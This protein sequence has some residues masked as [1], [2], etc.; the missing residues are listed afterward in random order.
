M[1]KLKKTFVL[2]TNVLLHTPYA[3]YSFAD[4]N[5][6]IPEVVLEELDKFKKDNTELGANARHVARLIDGLREKGNLNGVQKSF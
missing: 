1:K 5:I 4:N 3:L 6:V 2:D